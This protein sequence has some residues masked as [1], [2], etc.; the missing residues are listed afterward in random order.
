MKNSLLVLFAVASML[1]L[2]SCGYNGAVSKS[3]AI[4]ASWAKVQS[5]YQRRADLIPN[6]V[7]TVK[8]QAD[9]EKST[10]TAVIEARAKASSMNVNAKDLSPEKLKEFQEN[11][12]QLSQALGRFLQIVENYPDLKSNQAFMELQAQLEGTENRIN[13]ERNLFNEAVQDYNTHIKTFPNVLFSNMFGFKARAYFEADKG[14]EKAP[15]V[16]FK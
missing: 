4:D 1:S 13:T 14:S 6:L 9:F 5:A 8:G 11:Q 15:K 7:E 3:A 10:L 2:N 12:G 16:T